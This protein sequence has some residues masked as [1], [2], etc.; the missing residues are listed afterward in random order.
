M[1]PNKST[2]D[3]TAGGSVPQVGG[4]IVGRVGGA[5]SGG[6]MRAGNEPG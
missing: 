6:R 3:E 1:P 5:G 2:T 4:G